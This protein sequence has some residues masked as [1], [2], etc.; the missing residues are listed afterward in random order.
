MDRSMDLEDGNKLDVLE[1][2]FPSNLAY[3]TRCGQAFT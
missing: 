3:E 1:Y 2:L